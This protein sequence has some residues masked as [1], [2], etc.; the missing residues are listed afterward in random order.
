MSFLLLNT[1]TELACIYAS[2]S[3]Q[4]HISN[5]SQHKSHIIKRNDNTAK[6]RD[7]CATQSYPTGELFTLLNGASHVPCISQGCT[8]TSE[9]NSG[10]N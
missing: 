5:L 10:L 7:L 1:F 6:A 2:L 8:L 4:K 9:T 3:F